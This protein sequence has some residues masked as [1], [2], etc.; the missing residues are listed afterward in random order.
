MISNIPNYIWNIKRV[1]G[2]RDLVEDEKKDI[3]EDKLKENIELSPERTLY[4]VVFDNKPLQ[5]DAEYAI[6]MILE[7][8]YY[9]SGKVQDDS[10]QR[11]EI[12]KSIN[13][14][15]NQVIITVFLFQLIDL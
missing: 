6:S 7:Y 9:L 11:E 15:N 8:G 12:A 4:N 14:S 13:D 5:V 3:E 10:R 1:V 2:T